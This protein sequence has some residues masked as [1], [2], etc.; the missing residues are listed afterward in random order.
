MPQ[1]FSCIIFCR[2]D[3]L[4]SA[5]ARFE[6]KRKEKS[7]SNMYGPRRVVLRSN[8]RVAICG[9]EIP[10]SGGLYA[11]LGFWYKDNGLF[12]VDLISSEQQYSYV[13][14]DAIANK[15]LA[16]VGTKQELRQFVMSYWNNSLR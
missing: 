7:M 4:F 8:E 15:R 12:Y 14:R 9:S 1:L 10:G 16:G 2:C 5:L 13:R 11:P 6:R 3:Q